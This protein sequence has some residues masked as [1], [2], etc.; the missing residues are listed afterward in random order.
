MLTRL[1]PLLFWALLAGLPVR[2][3]TLP[4]GE[5]PAQ[6]TAYD[7]P[8]PLT[9][10]DIAVEGVEE[11]LRAFVRKASGLR[12]G[13][14]VEVPGDPA[15]SAAVRA[16]YRVGLFEDVKLLEAGREG[17][18]VRL[19]LRVRPVPRLTE[20]AFEGVGGRDRQALER[21]LPLFP[22]AYVRPS[23]LVRAEQI[24]RRHFVRQGYPLVK[25]RVERAGTGDG[26]LRLTFA[27][28]RGP[29]VE[30]AA[31]EIEGNR[32]L[33]DGTL[34]NVM[35]TRPPP[36]W[37]FWRKAPFNP[38][39]YREDLDRLLALYRERGYYD[40]RI[41][42]DTTYL[43]Y[44]DDNPEMVVEVEVAEGPRYHIRHVVWRGNEVFP[45]ET[46]TEALGLRPGD[47]YNGTRLEENL[48]F[49]E[50]GTDVTSRYMNRGY[51]RFNVVPSVQVVEGD[52]LDLIFEVFEG[53]VYTFG[54][55]E[56][57]GNYAVREH[58]I[59]RELATVPGRPFSRAAI[60]TS[61]MRLIGLG[62]FDPAVL[63]AGPEIRVDEARK[64]VDLTYRV[65]EV[66]RNP[67]SLGGSY[68]GDL[69]LQVG[70]NLDNFSL[71]NL[72]RPSTW[73]PL[74]AGDGQQLALGVQT[75]GADYQR[76]SLDF[77]EPWFRGRPEP[78]G[79]SVSYARIAD[80]FRS[81]TDGAG[82]LQAWSARVFHDRRLATHL[83][84]S[85]GLRY[86]HFDNRGWSTSLPEGRSH[87]LVVMPGLTYGT[88]DHPVL[89]RRGVLARLGVELA[90]AP[91]TVP[92]HKWR[93][94]GRALV[95]LT[96]RLGLEVSADLGYTASL[97]GAPQAFRRFMVGGSPFDAQGFDTFFGEDLV[98]L[99][100]YPARAIG[101]RDAEG[102]PVG[103]R[104]LTKYTAELQWH[105]VRK[106]RLAIV[107]YL[108]F[109]AANTWSSPAAYRPG[110]LF[111]AAGVGLRM[112]L[113]V[114]G[115]VEVSYGYNLDRFAPF[116]DHDGGRG[117][118]LQFTL[119][120]SFGF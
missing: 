63:A 120:R 31:L 17:G 116:G 41:V 13:Q 90:P 15:L 42:R 16:L 39:V 94:Q 73:N 12:V 92:Y 36:W 75:T 19:L 43:R 10:V 14:R 96:T 102:R 44:E 6:L 97:T 45:G 4:A 30:V 29:H 103:G 20:L 52:S 87:E 1:L 57:A 66:R 99:R 9:I 28:E 76:Y 24:I 54:E 100:G 59:R 50:A 68:T 70:L 74:P 35:K 113:P 98:Y 2:A 86:R 95:P 8:V 111:R 82:G 25:V 84:L 118:R 37:R 51:L 32:A 22:G 85:A 67:L 26:G 48:Y 18:S 117:W 38:D 23:D 115:F 58:V 106:P 27:V 101:P 112:T 78:L 107:P 80:G 77:V 72:F 110:D 7:R 3:Q 88:L 34:R 108:F 55:I 5:E 69:I 56:I 46:L 40:A 21:D 83:T 11:P 53:D 89:P 105:A 71:G 65:G 61:L 47:P 60:Q 104:L 62:L 91:G 81:G 64:T 33:S 114:L 93:L 109:D 49:N 79:V 119:G